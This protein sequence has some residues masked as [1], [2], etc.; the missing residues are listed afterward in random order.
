MTSPFQLQLY[1]PKVGEFPAFTFGFEVRLIGMSMTLLHE[2]WV[3]VEAIGTGQRYLVDAENA[4][5]TEPISLGVDPLALCGDLVFMIHNDRLWQTELGS[6]NWV[7]VQPCAGARSIVAAPASPWNY[8]VDGVTYMLVYEDSVELVPG[9]TH[10]YTAAVAHAVLLKD[11]CFVIAGGALYRN[12][13]MLVEG[14]SH[15]NGLFVRGDDV[16]VSLAGEPFIIQQNASRHHRCPQATR[17]CAKV[18]D[19]GDSQEALEQERG[20]SPGPGGSST[21]LEQLYRGLL[22]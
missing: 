21:A 2:L 8:P 10:T 12:S 1:H 5:T 4:W 9:G 6:L 13:E 11:S 22:Q 3:L 18:S 17:L 7:F 15:V 14:L 19:Q 20:E 16:F